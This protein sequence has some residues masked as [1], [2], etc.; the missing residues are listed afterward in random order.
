MQ[1]DL[2]TASDV[3]SERMSKQQKSQFRHRIFSLSP[4]KS[5]LAL[6]L[7]LVIIIIVVLIDPQMCDRGEI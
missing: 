5:I 7:L 6:F 2:A 1:P 4:R 3:L